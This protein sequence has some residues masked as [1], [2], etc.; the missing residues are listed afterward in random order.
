MD[1]ISEDGRQFGIDAH[2]V[3][4]VSEN[5]AIISS[6]R[7]RAAIARADMAEAARMLGRPYVISGHVC[8]G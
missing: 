5:D 3:E 6:S 1:M 4:L 8:H 7:I 2:T